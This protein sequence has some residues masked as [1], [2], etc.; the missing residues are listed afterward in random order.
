[1]TESPAIVPFDL[2][3]DLPSHKF[4]PV[5]VSTYQHIRHPYLAGDDCFLLASG[6]ISQT[7]ESITYELERAS[8]P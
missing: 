6:T 5:T 1:M 8:V 4:R 2:P 3:R 7:S